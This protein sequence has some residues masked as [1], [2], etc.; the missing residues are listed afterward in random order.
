MMTMC[1]SHCGGSCLLK[2]HVKDGVITRIETDNEEEPQLRG[3]LKGRALRKYVYAPDR[4]LYPMKRVGERGEGKFERISWDEALAKVASELKRVISSYGTSSILIDFMPGDQS[5]LH[6]WTWL[7]RLLGRFG[8]ITQTWS[9]ASFMGGN[10]ASMANYGTPYTTNNRDDLPNSKLIVMWGWDPAVSVT[11]TSACWWLSQAKE[12]GTRFIVI[13]PRYTD[14]AVVFADQWIPIRPSTDTALAVALAY[15]MIAEDLYDRKFVGTFTYG[16]DKFSDYVLGKEDGV[17]KTP[18][19]AEAITQVPVATIEKLARELATTKPTALMPS[20]APGRTSYG[21][22]FHRAV[23]TLAAMTGN[24][25][26]HG[27]S[28]GARA[29]ESLFGGY[30]YPMRWVNEKPEL[31]AKKDAPPSKEVLERRKKQIHR[32]EIPDMILRGKAAGYPNDCKF[33]LVS[34]S[35]YLNQ[36]TNINYTVKALKAVEFFAVVEQFMTPTAKF[37]DILLPANTFLERNDVAIGWHLPYVGHQPKIIESLGESKSHLDMAIE[38]ARHMGVHDLVDKSEEEL[39]RDM[40]AEAGVTDF[41]EFD[42]KGYHWFELPEPYVAFKEQIEDP[43]NH[44]FPTPSGKIEIYLD[45]WAELNNPE[46]PPVPKYIEAKESW[47]SPLAKKYPL[48][49]INAHAKNRA[50]SKFETNPWL[51]ELRAQVLQISPAD[52]L[53]RG[54]SDGDT[55]RVFNDRGELLITARVTD[56]IMPGVV[57]LPQGA[58]Y[59]PDEK[60]LDRGASANVLTHS[61]Y[62]PAGSSPFNTNLVQVERYEER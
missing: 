57:H 4:L 55:V 42:R 48:Q 41:E 24:V 14:S 38:L 54:I 22:Q 19:W 26:I 45:Y 9:N 7:N 8:A 18:A 32:L 47:L 13:D 43:K 29:W 33:F 12:R 44:P 20:G 53:E 40:A 51:K 61:D 1:A 5:Y 46:L 50:L 58:W 27:G 21:E 23:A 2:V 10:V 60:G 56:R 62:S 37:A 34:G 6:Q 16:F 15:V 31:F 11:G 28:P 49:F 25:G 35:N 36:T 39:V 3:C 17:A 59:N 30:P 52:A